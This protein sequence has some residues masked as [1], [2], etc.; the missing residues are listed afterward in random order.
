MR[1]VNVADNPICSIPECGKSVIAKGFCGKH[2]QRFNK[3]GDALYTAVTPKGEA[4]DFFHNYV[5]PYTGKECLIWPYSKNSDGYAHIYHGGKVRSAHRVVCEMVKGPPPT[6]GHEA[7]H[8][9]GNGN[10]GCVNPGHLFWKTRKQN[11]TDR[12]KHGTSNRG[13]QSYRAKLTREQVLQIRSLQG[14]KPNSEIA[15]LFGVSSKTVSKIHVRKIWG[16]MV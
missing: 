11:Q 13:E 7:A 9:C 16:W 8:E 1:G 2:Y 3:Y 15:R 6:K 14:A 12:V 4:M 10:K 5:L